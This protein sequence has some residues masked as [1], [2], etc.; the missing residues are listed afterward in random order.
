M[1]NIL[2]VD[3][4]KSVRKTMQTFLQ[5]KQY[6]VEVAA[7]ADKAIQLLKDKS[8]DVAV[9][10]IIL[11]RVNGLE[12]LKQ[13]QTLAPDVQV[14]IITGQPTVDTAA[15][16][17]RLGANEY[18]RKPI[19][20]EKLLKAVNHSVRLKQS[21][22]ERRRLQKENEKYQAN[23]EKLVE[24]RTQELKQAMD[25][26][27]ETQH[28]L[29]DQ[30]RQR[31]LTQMASGIAHDFNNALSPIQSVVELLLE[32]P[33]YRQNQNEL[34]HYLKHIQTSVNTAT[35][36]VR[37]L[38]KF[39]R[40]RDKEE[41]VP[42]DLNNII[43]EA[44]SVTEMKWKQEAQA[45][46]KQVNIRTELNDASTIEGNEAEL[47]EILTNLIF[48]AVEAMPEGGHIKISTHA[49]NDSVVL[50]FSDNGVGMSEETLQK[51][52][53]PFYTTKGDDGNGLGL[54]TLQGIVQRHN[55]SLSVDSTKGVG[56][57]FRIVF[58]HCQATLND[59]R[60]SEQLKNILPL[61]I[62]L[63]EDH[64]CQRELLQEMLQKDGHSVDVAKDGVEGLE[65]FYKG[66]YHVVITDRAMARMNGD[67][68][69]QKVK[70]KAPQKLVIMLTGFGDMMEANNEKPHAVDYLISKPANR[71]KLYSPLSQATEVITATPS[72][73]TPTEE[74]SN[75]T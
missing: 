32:D 65:L 37:R 25:D 2:L 46:G 63:V 55:G 67:Q 10:D 39:Y 8:F 43:K 49:E 5:Q 26:L 68:F 38:R 31:A 18:L 56:T 44:V 17:V 20:K 66:W 35:E 3:D 57:T 16:A 51:C 52:L 53:E 14:I 12:V 42:L 34:V 64:D 69:A 47:H 29:V 62:L 22:D 21:E 50:L 71:D 41:F 23:L 1:S 11:P 4:E 60:D 33:S 13:I 24:Q 28:Q 61:N 9:V 48:N 27:R 19:N 30:E 40:P 45:A 59:S 72:S 70:D 54:A 75:L 15:E 73:Q 7:E 36:T 6:E 74:N 58:P